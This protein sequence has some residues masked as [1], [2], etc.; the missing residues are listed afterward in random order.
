MPT[1]PYEEHLLA[2][3]DACTNC[4]RLIRVERIDPTRDGFGTEY[5]SHFSRRKRTTS[6]EYAPSD[7]PPRSKG[8]FC[9]CGVEG[10]RERLWSPDHVSRDRFKQLLVNAVRT[11]EL[12]DVSL[13]RK[14]TLAYGLQAFDG[15]AGPDAAIAEAVDAGIVAQA[16]SS[17][18]TDDSDAKPHRVAD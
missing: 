8:V 12:K 16:A 5:E 17:D 18:S 10:H 11:L 4:L 6:V 2:A 1:E 15:G 14:E 9:A 3:P 7:A 13:K